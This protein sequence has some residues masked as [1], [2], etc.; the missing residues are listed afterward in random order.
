MLA[1]PWLLKPVQPW[2]QLPHPA[3]AIPR[4]LPNDDMVRMCTP[5]EVLVRATLCVG[6]GHSYEESAISRWLQTH[7]TSP[8]T[9]EVLTTSALLPNH[10]QGR[11][12]EGWVRAVRLHS[13]CHLHHL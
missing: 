13:R 11:A 3:D 5:Q 2:Q 7:D 9:G 1:Q 6:N 12:Q 10:A 4:C 8:V